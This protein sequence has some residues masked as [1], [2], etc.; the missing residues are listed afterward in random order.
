MRVRAFAMELLIADV[1]I[2]IAGNSILYEAPY[3]SSDELERVSNSHKELSW[4][5]ERV[6]LG[7]AKR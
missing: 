2:L 4:V 3:L 1:L 5:P 6:L 7:G